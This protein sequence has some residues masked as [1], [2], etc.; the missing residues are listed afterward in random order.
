MEEMMQ[1]DQEESRLK[2]NDLEMMTVKKEELS[3]EL[4]QLKT[5]M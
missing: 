2:H 5:K 3:N 4:I 1:I